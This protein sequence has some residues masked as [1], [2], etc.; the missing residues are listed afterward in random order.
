VKVFYFLRVFACLTNLFFFLKKK[1][2]GNL[3]SEV[4]IAELAV[5]PTA[6]DATEMLALSQVLA[7]RCMFYCGT[8]FFFSSNYFV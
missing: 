1:I 4:S 6:L 7:T 8:F 5:F 3:Y 2:E